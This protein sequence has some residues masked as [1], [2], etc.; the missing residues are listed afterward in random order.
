[1]KVF[2]MHRDRNFE[3][4]RKLR[5]DEQAVIQDLELG[6]LLDAMARADK[7][8]LEVTKKAILSS[9]VDLDPILYRQN[10]L[11]D[12]LKNSYA[13]R[14]I[15]KIAVEAIEGER[16]VW[17]WY[18]PYKS[19]DQTLGRAVK[20]LQLLVGKLEG[21]RGIADQQ[22]DKFESEGFRAFFSMLKEELSDQYLASVKG[23]LAELEFRNGAL[24]SA[25]LGEGNKGTN[26]ALCKQQDKKSGLRGRVFGKNAPQQFTFTVDISDE[27]GGQMFSELK[28]RGINNLANTI[29][30]SSDHV[31]GFFNSVR[32]ELAF[33]VACLNLH[34]QLAQKGEPTCFPLPLERGK[35]T[36]SFEGLYDACLALK[37][38]QKVVSNDANAENKDL[39]V[40]T[41]ANRGG[42]STFLRSIGLAQLMMQ[43]GAFV[44]AKSFSS[45]VCNG[46]FTHF[47]REEDPNMKSGK[48]DEELSRM[49]DIVSHLSSNCMVLFN[50]S[51][52][53]TNEREGSEIARQIVGALLER[54]VKV[55][56][57]SHQYE[58]AQSFYERDMPNALF[59]RAERKPGGER[60][61]KIVRGEP[62]RTSYGEDL[63]NRIFLGIALSAASAAPVT[64]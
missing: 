40:I 53:A 3:L 10:V 51:F 1:M 38:D 52:A 12:C 37:L 45:D 60:S 13:V 31:L 50:E 33:Y 28:D 57:V 15:Y 30:Q 24:V 34:E 59:L 23:H 19:N 44:A 9:L 5:P 8:L 18:N 29:A 58:F 35:R 47:K 42:K 11:K 16:G 20:V 62:L 41:G 26:Y 6:V 61:F 48:L 54:R 43:C 21:L 2:L 46:V 17:G 22:A 56:F 25:E 55:F 14:D 64:S 7:F 63:Y 27:T 49:S 36:Q 32:V 39:V 4:G